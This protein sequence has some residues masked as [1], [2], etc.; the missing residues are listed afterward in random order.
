MQFVD[1][2]H[3][4]TIPLGVDEKGFVY[5]YEFT[6]TNTTVLGA[7]VTCSGKTNLLRNIGL[8]LLKRGTDN[9]SLFIISVNKYKEYEE[10]EEYGVPVAKTME[11]AIHILG[12]LNSILVNEKEDQ[13]NIVL[14]IDEL[15]ELLVHSRKEYS[16]L[17]Q[18][19]RK[20]IKNIA[21]LGSNKNITQF[22]FTQRPSSDLIDDT[23]KK[24]AKIRIGCGNLPQTVSDMLFEDKT[25]DVIPSSPHR[26]IGIKNEKGYFIVLDSFFAPEGVVQMYLGETRDIFEN[27]RFIYYYR[28]QKY[29]ER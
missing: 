20:Y 19:A 15:A 26:L 21:L 4:N 28:N 22:I 25:I 2:K 17:A 5:H 7:G 8:S 23:V 9:N 13:G 14:I 24:S 6:P 3:F 27:N 11:E 16:E 18:K 10:F 12:Y 1:E 29:L